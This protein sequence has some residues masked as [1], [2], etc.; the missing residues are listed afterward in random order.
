MPENL[1][2]EEQI[3]EAFKKLASKACFG[4]GIE[5][6]IMSVNDTMSAEE[7][8][9]DIETVAAKYDKQCPLSDSIFNEPIR[10]YREGYQGENKRVKGKRLAG[11]Q[12]IECHIRK[13]QKSIL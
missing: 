1:T 5:A 8:V 11:L 2:A 12:R 3:I 6:W 7:I 10:D 9:E 13:T 4:S